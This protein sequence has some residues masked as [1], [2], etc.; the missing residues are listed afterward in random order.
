MFYTHM[1]C[2]DLVQYHHRSLLSP[3]C[4]MTPIYLLYDEYIRGCLL[5]LCLLM[6]QVAGCSL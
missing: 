6:Q 4:G 5:H 1:R 2:P 3:R